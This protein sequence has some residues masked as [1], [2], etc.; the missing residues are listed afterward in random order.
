MPESRG[1]EEVN[2]SIANAQQDAF[3]ELESIK[4]FDFALSRLRFRCE[5]LEIQMGARADLM[6]ISRK[7]LP[8]SLSSAISS[9]TAFQAI[10]AR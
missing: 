7:R 4:K 10:D 3:L 9:F 5:L 8:I 1:R 2:G 6:F